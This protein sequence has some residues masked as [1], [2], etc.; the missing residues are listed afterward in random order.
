MPAAFLHSRPPVGRV[1]LTV[2][3]VSHGR[4]QPDRRDRRRPQTM[5]ERPESRP[6]RRCGRPAA[7]S[8]PPANRLSDRVRRL[9]LRR[10][11]RRW[12]AEATQPPG[13]R[14][15]TM[16]STEKEAHRRR[17]LEH[18]THMAA[19][20]Q[21]SAAPTH[22]DPQFAIRLVGEVRRDEAEPRPSRRRRRRGADASQPDL[23]GI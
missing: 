10:L 22:T 21:R 4:I 19:S 15:I 11:E 8:R 7:H 17:M 6:A 12:Q 23:R 1:C 9:M 16:V 20:G 18:L 13:I 2:S 14:A 3:S 5:P